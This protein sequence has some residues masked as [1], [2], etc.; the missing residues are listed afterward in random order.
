MIVNALS[1]MLLLLGGAF[2]GQLIKS[3][4]RRRVVRAD[5][6]ETLGD[7]AGKLGALS[8]EQV[9]AAHTEATAA[10]MEA[11]QARRDVF[12][13]QVT[14]SRLT[15]EADSLLARMRS[16]QKEIWRATATIDTVRALVGPMP[17]AT[18]NGRYPG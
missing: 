3:I 5:A 17:P 9:T 16:W 4:A 2:G 8:L 10:R 13:L 6:V 18:E 11:A 15:V 7:V 12:E 14:V 1:S